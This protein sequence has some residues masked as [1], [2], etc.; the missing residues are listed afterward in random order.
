M[1]LKF[2]GQLKKILTGSISG[3]RDKTEQRDLFSL[4]GKLRSY[5][6]LPH[7]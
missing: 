4:R 1:I 6:Y 3:P 2:T 5:I 7:T